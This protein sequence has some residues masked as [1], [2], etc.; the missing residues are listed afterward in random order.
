M[1]SIFLIILFTSLSRSVVAQTTNWEYLLEP[2]KNLAFTPYINQNSISTIKLINIKGYKEEDF[3]FTLTLRDA[4]L[5]DHYQWF[6]DEQ[7]KQPLSK[8]ELNDI[9]F[10]IVIDTVVAHDFI[11]PDIRIINKDFK[12][13][14]NRFPG[15][16]NSYQVKQHWD[17]NKKTLKLHTRIEQI[18]FIFT[19]KINSK[20]YQ[21]DTIFIPF[22]NNKYRSK[23][24]IAKHK[25]QSTWAKRIVYIGEFNTIN[26]RL[27]SSL[28][29][30]ASSQSL[31]LKKNTISQEIENSFY[32]TST[33]DHTKDTIIYISE[34][35][36][37]AFFEA[38]KEKIGGFEVDLPAVK[39][40]DIK[41]WY[42]VQDWY[43]N[44]SKMSFETNIIAVSPATNRYTETDYDNKYLPHQP[45]FWIVFDEQFLEFTQD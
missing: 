40:V 35:E 18:A 9:C 26:L 20:N 15:N 28:K 22:N 16:I 31:V 42:I 2:V 8:K 21:T 27:M 5:N 38:K 32:S 33:T 12:G 41:Y 13:F 17:F 6:R 43:F 37:R 14:K 3:L 36:A 24:K 11:S 19:P 4:A 10:P 23:R 39:L 29:S 45:T 44:P 30:Y 1:R 25:T 7:L 34:A